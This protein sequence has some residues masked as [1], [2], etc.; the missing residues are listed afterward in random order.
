MSGLLA[1][2]GGFS[3]R[4]KW[5]VIGA[6]V[7][8]LFVSIAGE[9]A[10]SQP[11]TTT[12]TVNSL[13]SV[14]TLHQV[15]HEFNGFGSTNG[16]TV[17]FAAPSGQRLTAA[18]QRTI[19]QL[20]SALKTLPGV[21]SAPDPFASAVK[22]LSPDG[23]VG[24]IPVAATGS[25]PSSA[26][27]NG[28]T[29]AV[30]HANSAQLQVATSDATAPPAGSSQLVGIILALIILLITFGS[31]MA[32][33]LPLLAA[34]LG[35]VIS[36]AGISMATAFVSLNSITP[37]LAQLLALAVGIDYSLFIVNRHSTQLRAGMDRR[38]SI[39][40]A[41]GT[42]GTAVFFAAATVIVALVGLSV[43]NIDFLTDMGVAAA[44]GVAIAML[45]ALTLTPALLDLIG[46]FALSRRAR[47]RVAT[48][49][50][51]RTGRASQRWMRA[52]GRHPALFTVAGLALLAI[53]AVP[54]FSMR[55][56]LAN[57]GTQPSGSSERTEFQL[58]SEGFGTGVN[59]PILVSA[60]FPST[61]VSP[62]GVAALT[63]TLEHTRDVSRV[64]PVAAHDSD[65]LLTVLPS[66]GPSDDATVALVN[67]L[68]HLST[69]T[70]S[71]Q[72]SLQVTGETAVQIDISQDL[73]GVL[74]LYLAIVAGFAFI[75]LLVVF[76]SVLIPLKAAVGFLLSL[77][78]TLGCTVAVYQWGWLGTVF[79]V[80]PAAPLLSL[81]PIIV[82][83]VLFGLS[84]DYEM[85]LISGMHEQHDAKN[86]GPQQSVVLGFSQGAKVVAAA[87][88]I[89]VSVFGSG[90]F[91]GTQGLRPIAFALAFGVLVDAFVVRMTLVPAVMLMFGRASW[92]IPNWLRRVIPHVDI[93]G[94]SL[95]SLESASVPIAVMAD[96]ANSPE[97]AKVNA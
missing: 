78:A 90:I 75:L 80:D 79:G 63:T 2:L 15:E 62:G 6:W 64:I 76:R 50:T 16:V 77:G 1:R 96:S 29:N 68:R 22:T 27:I 7:V 52:I 5:W 32:A 34:L 12:F 24:Y 21:K 86:A 69:S 13:Q 57:G 94:A 31:F 39:V 43:A 23:R 47:R 73:L 18:D 11:M 42:A 35:L 88:L 84:M 45:V 61:T 93:E 56:G 82:I 38:T 91:S 81:L 67:A 49:T 33:G 40:R 87:A 55:L 41:T 59:G 30:Q 8:I 51:P 60:H 46:R 10:L 70:I 66:S 26:T 19:A 72:P 17:A 53:L 97:S 58:M 92:W 54:V 44:A 65:V 74:P 9:S 71:G 4:H 36:L 14:R 28:I 37:A 48:G 85:F 83:A 3:A 95:G 89:M 25:T 20:S